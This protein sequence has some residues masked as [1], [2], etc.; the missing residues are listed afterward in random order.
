[1]YK[2]HE[3]AR[4]VRKNQLI[5]ITPKGEDT[6][7]WYT[8]LWQDD[9]PETPHK[10]INDITKSLDSRNSSIANIGK[11]RTLV[12]F[13][14]IN[15]TDYIVVA[16]RVS[17]G[18]ISANYGYI[19]MTTFDQFNRTDRFKLKKVPRGIRAQYYCISPSYLSQDGEYRSHWYEY[20]DKFLVEYFF[21]QIW[22]ELENYI[23]A[24]VESESLSLEYDIFYPTVEVEKYSLEVDEII[25][26]TRASIRYFAHFWFVQASLLSQG[27]QENHVN[28]K[29]NQLFFQNLKEDLKFFKA[30]CE[31]H[32][33]DKIM[34]MIRYM[35]E[36]VNR[37][38]KD[39][40]VIPVL[41]KINLGQKFRPLNVTDVQEPLNIIHAPWREIYITKLVSDITLNFQCPS[42]P[43]ILG[44]FYIKSG[45]PGLYDNDQQFK[46]LELS[47]RA[48]LISRRLR[49]VQRLTYH[50]ADEG[51]KYLNEAFHHLSDGIE[52]PVNFAKTHLMMSN[53]TLAFVSEYVGRTFY[54]IPA[55][56][57]SRVWLERVGN[58]IKDFNI[59][60][61]RIW[62]IAYAVLCMN[63]NKIIHNDLHLNNCTLHDITLMDLDEKKQY[64]EL[65]CVEDYY[66]MF[67]SRGMYSHI[68]D[69]SRAIII[70]ERVKNYEYFKNDPEAFHEFVDD[71]NDRIV[72]NLIDK[73]PTT[74][75]PIEEQLR[76]LL[77]SNFE[78]IFRIYTAIDLYDFC[79][80][81]IDYIGNQL[82]KQSL[83]LLKQIFKICEH[84]L[85]NILI[86][87]INTPEIKVEPPIRRVLR[88][89]FVDRL[90][91]PANPPKNV[92][93][94][95]VWNFERGVKFHTTGDYKNYP[96]WLREGK[97]MGTDGVIHDSEYHHIRDQ[98]MINTL[99]YRKESMAMVR[100]IADRHRLKY[101]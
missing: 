55:L 88:E 18:T 31:K 68:I 8:K 51:K 35:S 40:Q 69:M 57:K 91:N 44:W 2:I 94:L 1:M 82:P 72:R 15:L 76:E 5:K 39:G 14:P 80:K 101:L 63:H 93:I 47:D 75:R 43:I 16:L 81:L 52:A 65:Y 78:A 12:K 4:L 59:F 79:G 7:R 54:D 3:D 53:V 46:R 38:L 30:L 6:R 20:D 64:H 28:P 29:F 85:T 98:I 73:F 89:C 87:V 11:M 97:V 33:Y 83:D 66:W 92:N 74:F 95:D 86:R 99:K 26:G 27:L 34:T 42:F 17:N 23:S 37:G 36:T 49:D 90:I 21:T 45:K 10:W 71:Q 77:I 67:P 70:P 32:T 25:M 9:A 60:Q 24:K 61:T 41:A 19:Y 56:I 13:T 22:N 58:I 50:G 84:Y 100:Y 62:H 96:P 48:H